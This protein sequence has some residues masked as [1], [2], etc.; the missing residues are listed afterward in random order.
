MKIKFEGKTRQV[1][2]PMPIS[3]IFEKEIKQSEYPIIGSIVNNEYKNLQDII[4]EDSSV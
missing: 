2:E 4:K 1:K 3:K